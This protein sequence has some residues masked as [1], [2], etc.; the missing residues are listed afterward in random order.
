MNFIFRHAKYKIDKYNDR[1]FHAIKKPIFLKDFF[2]VNQEYVDLQDLISNIEDEEKKAII[3]SDLD[4]VGKK[5]SHDNNLYFEIC[6]SHLT[7]LCIYDG[8][9]VYEGESFSFDFLLITSKNIC[10][11]DN[12]SLV[13]KVK[14]DE[15][16][17]FYLTSD[18]GSTQIS[19][20][21]ILQNKLKIRFL[22]KIL[23]KEFDL[24][25]LPYLNLIVNC[26]EEGFNDKT[27]C[28]LEVKDTILMFSELVPYLYKQNNVEFNITD[29]NMYKIGNK[30]LSLC[31]DTR[32]DYFTKYNINKDVYL[33]KKQNS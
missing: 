21:P 3:K 29:E 6:N 4:K 14:I 30:L 23:N 18:K 20:N 12:T 15:E 28:P 25:N 9:I 26:E 11:I 7:A 19:P 17:K 1:F 22:E 5:L 31:E 27:G 24:N 32:I 16:G 8:N 13:G 33:S 10:V 2:K